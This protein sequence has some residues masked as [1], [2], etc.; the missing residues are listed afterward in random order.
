MGIR[1]SKCADDA[2]LELRQWLLCSKCFWQPEQSAGCCQHR[3]CHG[4]VHCGDG[5]GSNCSNV[6]AGVLP[7]PEQRQSCS[8]PPWLLWRLSVSADSPG[9]R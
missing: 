6:P 5:A 1:G 3:H 2:F 7:G 4:R 8:G 9:G